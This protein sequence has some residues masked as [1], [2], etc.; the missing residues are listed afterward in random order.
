MDDLLH[1]QRSKCPSPKV[2]LNALSGGK[3]ARYVERGDV[4]GPGRAE[5]RPTMVEAQLISQAPKKALR[6]ADIERV[7][8]AIGPT[9]VRQR[10]T[11]V[12]R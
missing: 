11:P 6:F 12:R 7:P 10:L 8:E 2:G 1:V 4:R 5:A 3:V 9:V